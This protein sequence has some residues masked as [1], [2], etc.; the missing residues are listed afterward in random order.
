MN[1]LS[2]DVGGTAIKHALLEETGK[3]VA[4]DSCGT[5]RDNPVD[6]LSTLKTLAETYQNRYGKLAGAAFSFPG[7]VDEEQG[8]IHNILALP[9][10]RGIP[11]LKELSA[12]LNLPVTMEND[13]N[14]AALGENWLGAARGARDV[15]FVVCGTGV[16]G[17]LLHDGHVL[18]GSHFLCGEIGLMRLA[19]DGPLLN[20]AGS[21]GGLVKRVAKAKRL[22]EDSLDGEQVFGMAEAGDVFVREQIDY[23]YQALAQGLVNAQYFYDPDIFLMGGAISS[24]P[25][26]VPALQKY[27]RAIIDKEPELAVEPT[28][29]AC[30]HGNTANLLGAARHF[31]QR[32]PTS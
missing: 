24:R 5:P 15:C 7:S 20:D 9:Y 8:V 3:I 21:V 18:H 32:F 22:P 28:I 13:A 1:I 2:I 25:D 4:Q 19:A 11:L 16:G 30:R 12:A 17:A 23:M 31:L 26:F 10:L 14:C 29:T 6:F 27:V